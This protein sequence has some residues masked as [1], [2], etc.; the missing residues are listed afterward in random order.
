[1]IFASALKRAVFTAGNDVRELYAPQTTNERYRTFWMTQTKFLSRLL[2]TRLA[3]VCAIR[4][5][6][7]AGGTVVA[8]CCDY[9]AQTTRG[10]F[11]LNEVALGIAVPK[12]W[13][14]LFLNRCNDRVKGEFLLHTGSLLEPSEA[15]ALGLIDEVVS[16]DELMTA[17]E[18]AMERLLKHP[19]VARATTKDTIRAP[20]SAQWLAYG[21]EEARDGWKMLNE[22]RVVE[23]L[24]GVLMRLS[25][26][27]AKL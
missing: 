21:E 10:T 15:K 24:G 14:E 18:T 13:A 19:S 3:T 16:E 26:G 5:A 17:A 8:L 9:R 7:P 23:A 25:G 4:G 27:K 2:K 12:Y 22:P 11:G 20:F 6:C 1:V